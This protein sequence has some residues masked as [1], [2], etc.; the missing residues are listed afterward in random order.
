[1]LRWSGICIM[2]SVSWSW[3]ITSE[4][5]WLLLHNLRFQFSFKQTAS[6]HDWSETLSVWESSVDFRQLS[7]EDFD[8]D[9][10]QCTVFLHGQKRECT[11]EVMLL[12]FFPYA[13]QIME[14]ILR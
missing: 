9:S 11:Q 6:P 4:T 8:R 14:L 1:M 10:I 12:L 3:I 2:M 7:W 13:N 5:I